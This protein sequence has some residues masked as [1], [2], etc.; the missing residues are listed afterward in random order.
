MKENYLFYEEQKFTQ[1]W[2]WLLLL[3]IIGYLLF[4]LISF[5]YSS[6]EI[7]TVGTII[8]NTENLIPLI[9]VCL[10]ILLF[11][12][13]KL[14]TTLSQDYIQISFFPFFTKKWNWSEINTTDIVTYGFVGY[15]IRL[16]LKYGTVYNIK[17]NHGLAIHLKNGKKLMVGTQKPEELANVIKNK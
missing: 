5:S 14:K 1:W 6:D 9:L 11:L 7:F 4:D 15:G 3:L 2:L 8:F 10:V 12:I 13:L 17:G 16:S